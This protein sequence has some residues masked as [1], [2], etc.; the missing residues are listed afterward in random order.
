[1]KKILELSVKEYAELKGVTI[2]AIYKAIKRGTLKHRKIGSLTI[3][4]VE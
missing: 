2:D 4:I 1:M 3:V